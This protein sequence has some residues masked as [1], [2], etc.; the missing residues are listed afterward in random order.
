MLVC[1]ADTACDPNDSGYHTLQAQDLC[2]GD[3]EGCDQADESSCGSWPEKSSS[4]SRQECLPCADESSF[5][6]LDQSY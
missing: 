5:R 2:E 4:K 1:L 6:Y 3:M